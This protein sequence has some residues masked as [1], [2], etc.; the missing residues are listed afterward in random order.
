VEDMEVGP[1][2]NSPCPPRGGETTTGRLKAFPPFGLQWLKHCL[3]QRC[4]T[5]TALSSSMV[6]MKEPTFGRGSLQQLGLREILFTVGISVE[7][8]S[9]ALT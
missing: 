3:L 8:G 4:G 9:C 1:M 7:K 5:G 6:S 2:P